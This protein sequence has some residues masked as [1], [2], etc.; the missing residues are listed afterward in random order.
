MSETKSGDTPKDTGA[1]AA[2]DV[3]EAA[4]EEAGRVDDQLSNAQDERQTSEV[5]ETTQASEPQQ[6]SGF[7]ATALKYLLIILVVFGLSLWLAPKLMPYMPASI[8]K[9]MQPGQAVLD[10]RLAAMDAA[11]AEQSEA[12]EQ[13]AALKAQ[14]EA[15][16]ERLA[17]A[18]AAAE[19]AKV[20]AEA[21]QQAAEAAT[22]NAAGGGAAADIVAAARD[23]A[24]EAAATAE[25]AQ[26]AATEAG[27]VASAAT[28][29]TASLARQMTSF[30][31]RLADTTEELGGLS[32]SLANTSGAAGGATPELAAAF[33]ALKARV[34]G[35]VD[36]AASSEFLTQTDA[37]RF[38]TLDDLR[39]SRLAIEAELRAAV[40][41]PSA[42]ATDSD[43]KLMS[44]DTDQKISS[45]SERIDSVAATAEQATAT[46]SEAA[47]TTAEAVGRVDTAIRGASLRSAI[48]ALK[49][50]IDH[51]SPFETQLTEIEA[52]TG[53]AAPDALHAVAS[54]GVDPAG[55]LSRSFAVPA[56]E[57]IAADI[58]T[59]AGDGIASQA[60][61]WLQ[62]QVAGR[63][64]AEQ[65]GESVPA[66]VS[67]I[68]ARLGEGD[69]SAA[70]AEA[71]T[72]PEESKA[73]LAE[74]LDKL[75]SRV[76][77]DQA[78]GEFANGLGG[79]QG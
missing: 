46:A 3:T 28:R 62:G 47:S 61:A 11:I 35:L 26:V 21:A 12:A 49:S 5:E 52:L 64:S 14:T 45:L 24:R 76:A 17:A 55:A 77:A 19:A 69:L 33:S 57:A 54:G 66:I 53:N 10:E 72:L 73:A 25:T 18:E 7:A 41:D 36:Q 34:D 23:A 16:T 70:L 30:E 22:A 15:L 37:E 4:A 13:V 27:K 51:G 38:A 31:A 63:P 9:H 79:E 40:P 56:Q 78:F 44:E 29:D 42:V 68:D 60:G 50:R 48:A 59:R 6:G 58:K 1:A 67:R 43:L 65:A 20:E 75:R 2:Q 71:E 8:A 39:S 32:A 74:W